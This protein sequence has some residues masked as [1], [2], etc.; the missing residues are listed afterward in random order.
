[1]LLAF[2]FYRWRLRLV[3]RRNRAL[4]QEIDQRRK[5]EQE[6]ERLITELEAR[7]A[8]LER[9]TYTVS[10]DLKSPLVTIRGFL[11][12]LKMDAEA[13]DQA[14]LETDLAHI[15]RAAETM[16]RILDDLLELSRVGRVVHAV[17]RIELSELAGEA[18][19]MVASQATQLGAEIT[20]AP[21][22]PVVEGDRTRLLEVFVNLFENALKFRR[23]EESPR[24]E[25]GVRHQEPADVI[26]VRDNGVGIKA[27]YQEKVF[28]LFERLQ[29]EVDGTGIGLALVRRIVEFHGGRIWV[30]SAGPGT[31]STFCFTL[32][33]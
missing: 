5:A 1:M 17:G 3:E 6:R 32:G 28:G 18:A 4:Q 31:G 14:R 27:R 12:L 7:N 23:V 11:G 16:G 30:E 20:I 15:G 25:I 13:G 29:P 10:H 26:F 2:S 9:F 19:R 22:L 8:E 24:I 33:A 21:D